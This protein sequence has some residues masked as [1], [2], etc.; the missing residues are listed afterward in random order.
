M[1]DLEKQIFFQDVL[2]TGPTNSRSTLQQIF[3]ENPVNVRHYSKL[4]RYVSKQ[5]R[6]NVL[7]S[8]VIHSSEERKMISNIDWGH[9]VVKM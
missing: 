3:I 4:Q 8:H 2:S 7:P 6:Q 5:V 1:G 9:Y